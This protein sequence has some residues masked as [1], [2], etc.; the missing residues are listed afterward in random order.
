MTS[1][2]R[3]VL[4][5]TDTV[6]GVWTY[7]LDLCGALGQLGVEVV[8]ASMGRLPS[9]EQRARAASIPT[10]TLVESSY[11][12]EWM[13]DPWSDV[14]RAGGW[15]LDL[16]QRH[17]PDI[18]HL[19]G[20]VHGGLPFRA[21]VLLVG[22]SCVLSWWQAVLGEPAP[23]QYNTYANLVR[24]GL[25]SADLVVAPTS[26][27]LLALRRHYGAIRRAQVVPNGCDLDTFKP[28]EKRPLVVAAGRLWDQA[29]N[30]QTLARA[31]R[32][33]RWPIQIAGEVESPSGTS[34]ERAQLGEAVTLTGQLPR[35][36]LAELFS[37][38]AI[39]ASPARYEPFGLSV[40]EAAASG[41][42]LVLG[43]IDSL[44]ELWDGAALFVQPDDELA[45][46]DAITTLANDP[47]QRER[48][49]Q[50]ARLRAARYGLAP[51]A[52]RYRELY[53]ELVRARKPVRLA[54]PTDHARRSSRVS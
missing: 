23:V 41:A 2:V 49:A 31:A 45:W 6:G 37:H 25:T 39:Y 46:A 42:A 24:A 54:T 13:D 9:P 30:L 32:H 22:H 51:F 11:K 18:V 5:T 50:R 52:R 16:E 15:L 19:N 40:L 44:R 38:A 53:Q 10:L 43:D 36:A 21:P 35:P 20:Y 17:A 8:L 3:R 1:R 14:A 47:E 29:K 12:L 28:R 48:L 7:A 4:M 34:A 26:A 27:M 33:V